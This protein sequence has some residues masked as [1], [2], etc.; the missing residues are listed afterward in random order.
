MRGG[1][2]DTAVC[3]G[4]VALPWGESRA[5]KERVDRLLIVSNRLPV[6]VKA[7]L[8]EVRVVPSAGGLATG[9]RGP[10]ERSNGLLRVSSC[11]AQLRIQARVVCEL[12][13]KCDGRPVRVPRH[14]R[15][16]FVKAHHPLN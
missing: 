9:L 11:A 10:H 15:R 12:A 3:A 14:V 1:S 4:T 8:G 7:E 16:R 6:T 2:K 13:E 5:M